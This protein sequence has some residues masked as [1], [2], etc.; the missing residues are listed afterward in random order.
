MFKENVNEECVEIRPQTTSK[1]H[2]KVLFSLMLQKEE[3][4]Q[5]HVK[6]KKVVT[7][8]LN[9]NFLRSKHFKTSLI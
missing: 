9:Q 6:N 8:G 4:F 1:S 5:K 3:T 2:W 7:A